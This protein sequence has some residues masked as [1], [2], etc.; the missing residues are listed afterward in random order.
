MQNLRHSLTGC[1]IRN[2]PACERSLCLFNLCAISL[3]A[4][5]MPQFL[6]GYNKKLSN[7]CT[8]SLCAEFVS[9]CVSF[10][11]LCFP[12]A[13]EECFRGALMCCEVGSREASGAKC[14]YAGCILWGLSPSQSQ[15]VGF[16][17]R[18]MPRTNDTVTRQGFINEGQWLD[19]PTASALSVAIAD[20]HLF[21]L[22]DNETCVLEWSGSGVYAVH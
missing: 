14:Q 15:T 8:I 22:T 20:L 2:Y 5:F 13:P 6:T 12:K 1:I 7:L 18:L 16:F 9:Q 19:F 3:C 4:E 17:C 11:Q 10:S 21:G